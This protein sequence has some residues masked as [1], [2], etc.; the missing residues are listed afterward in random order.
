MIVLLVVITTSVQAITPMHSTLILVHGALFTSTVWAPV[1]TILQTKGYNVITLDT[2]GRM[3]DG[4]APQEATLSAAVEKLCRVIDLQS[5]PVI[6]VGHNQ[7]GAIMTQA[8]AQCGAR[9]RSLVYLAAVLPLS[10][11]RPFDMLSDQDNH[12]FDRCAPLDLKTGL[13]EPDMTAP[14]KALLMADAEDSAAQHAIRNMVSESITMA[15]DTLNYNQIQFEHIPK[16]YIK[17]TQDLMISPESQD[18]FIARQTL[19]RVFLLNTGH[20]PFISQPQAL[21]SILM[22]IDALEFNPDQST[23]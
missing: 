11:E 16:Y 9:M 21:A 23:F 4:V 10:G 17:T 12:N 5:E 8:T 6:L 7:A 15:Y 3:N 19:K 2:P 14:I 1:Q 20:A 13:S 18:K 22:D